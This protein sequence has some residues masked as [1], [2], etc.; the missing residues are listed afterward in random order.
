MRKQAPPAPAPPE[1][2]QCTTPRLCGTP[3]LHEKRGPRCKGRA[4]GPDEC[5]CINDC[6]DDPWLRDGR[7]RGCARYYRGEQPIY[8]A[9]YHAT[10]LIVGPFTPLPYDLEVPKELSWP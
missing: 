7:A 6:G 9:V 5:D 2:P 10:D 3:A 8:L 1:C 4:C